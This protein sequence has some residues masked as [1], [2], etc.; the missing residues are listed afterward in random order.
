MFKGRGW[1]I[2]KYPVID[3]HASLSLGKARGRKMT[4]PY[5]HSH[6]EKVVM[7]LSTSLAF[8]FFLLN[9]LRSPQFHAHACITEL[10]EFQIRKGNY[11][12]RVGS[13]ALVYLVAVMECIAPELLELTSNAARDNKKICI[14]SSPFG[15]HKHVPRPCPALNKSIFT[16]VYDDTEYSDPIGRGGTLAHVE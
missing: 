15:H 6:F 9:Y 12:E 3:C 14:P 11:A 5:G 2:P 7:N 4:S 1:C 10:S 13:D 8:L 16:H